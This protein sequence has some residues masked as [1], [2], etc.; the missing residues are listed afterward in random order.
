[1]FCIDFVGRFIELYS[2]NFTSVANISC[3]IIVMIHNMMCLDTSV[4]YYVIMYLQRQQAPHELNFESVGSNE[5][6]F[7]CFV[8]NSAC[9]FCAHLSTCGPAFC[10]LDS[11]YN[12][13]LFRTSDLT[14]T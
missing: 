5:F 2:T 12:T 13:Q 6:S 3:I 4:F 7:V 8:R 10:Y 1:M 14:A 11:S 9:P